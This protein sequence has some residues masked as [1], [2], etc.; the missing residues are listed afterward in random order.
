[1]DLSNATRR[2][3]L[4]SAAAGALT[5]C[6]SGAGMQ[7]TPAPVIA[8]NTVQ[9]D[10]HAAVSRDKKTAIPTLAARPNAAQ[11][12]NHA[13]TW[14]SPDVDGAPRLLFISDYG[15]DAVDIFTMP[16][17]KLKGTITG[18]SSPEGECTDAKGNLWVA[19]TGLQEMLQYSRTGTLLNTLSVP[20]EY[21]A[22]CAVDKATGDLAVSNIESTSGPG[23][24]VIFKNASGT[25]TAYSNPSIYQY[26]FL[27]YDPNGNL[28]FDGTDSSRTSSYFAE[29]P[30][31]SGTTKTIALSG[32][33]LHFA[34]MV[35][36]DKAGNYV[37]LGDQQCGGAPAACIYW[38]SVSGSGGT[39]TGT[40][41]LS[42]Y[43]GGSVCDLTQGAIAANGQQYVAGADYETCGYTA[44]TADRW[45]YPAGGMPTNDNTT[46]SFVEPI[47]A[48]V[49][50]K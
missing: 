29:L 18:L 5:A 17:M 20:N 50:E 32:G 1:M 44:T 7:T 4:A 6:S 2:A 47:G 34:G 31:G 48:A 39:V 40:T 25:G 43:Q 10:A 42:N 26:F 21:P 12:P 49:Y 16:A 33:T 27:G 41:T 11:H 13:K 35:Q 30:V 8:P 15:A 3:L 14:V 23:D 9:T 46:A 22:S 28:F 38:V 19:N 45:A 37:A 36:W 24:I